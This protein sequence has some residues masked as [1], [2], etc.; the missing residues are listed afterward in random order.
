MLVPKLYL[1][2]TSQPEYFNASTTPV[3]IF[4]KTFY[5]LS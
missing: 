1:E 3:N 4:G 5:L 2:I